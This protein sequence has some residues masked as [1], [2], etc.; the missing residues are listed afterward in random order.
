LVTA[1]FVPVVMHAAI[2]F[3]DPA[4]H[5]AFSELTALKDISNKKRRKQND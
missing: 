3:A 1:F 5:Y 4:K 2:R